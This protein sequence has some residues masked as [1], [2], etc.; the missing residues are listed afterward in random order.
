M[1]FNTFKNL[2]RGITANT[3]IRTN[4]FSTITRAVD[5]M[6]KRQ[7]KKQLTQT[8]NKKRVKE[9]DVNLS[10]RDGRVIVLEF[11]GGGFVLGS[12]PFAVSTPGG[13]EFHQK[14]VVLANI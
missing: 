4:I 10:Q 6:V 7:D 1:C 12:Q 8:K 11:S 13:E 3:I 9:M 5:L 14:R 2:K